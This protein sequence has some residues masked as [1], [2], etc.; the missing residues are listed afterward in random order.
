MLVVEPVS[1]WGGAYVRQSPCGTFDT[2][3]VTAKPIL[4]P[5][6]SGSRLLIKLVL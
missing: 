4:T 1:A 6:A 3:S 2:M 5:L